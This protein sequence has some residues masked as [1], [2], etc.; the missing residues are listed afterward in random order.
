M[1]QFKASFHPL[2]F[3]MVHEFMHI[4][5][6]RTSKR[7]CI[8]IWTKGK[9]RNREENYCKNTRKR[10]G[11]GCISVS[12]LLSWPGAQQHKHN[13]S[14]ALLFIRCSQTGGRRVTAVGSRMAEGKVW[15]VTNMI[16]T[17][18]V[19]KQECADAD[20]TKVQLLCSH[21]SYWVEKFAVWVTFGREVQEKVNSCQR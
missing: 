18:K 12:K 3:Y 16:Y 1:L 2:E 15:S 13:A 5:H 10:L 14:T 21:S 20:L 7:W 19:N 6:C 11:F 8:V 17:Q 4:Y 9:M